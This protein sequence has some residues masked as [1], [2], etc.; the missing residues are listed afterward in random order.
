MVKSWLSNINEQRVRLG[1]IKIDLDLI[2]FSVFS[3]ILC[4]GI[5]FEGG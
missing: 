3:E 4:F 5:L 2:F 1:Q